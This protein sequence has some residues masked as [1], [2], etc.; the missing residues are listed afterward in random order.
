MLGSELVIRALARRG[1]TTIFSLSG[2]Q[3]MPL[4]DACIDAGIRIVHVR[5]EAAAV[6][7]ADAWS[8]VTGEIGVA[9]LTAAP[10][11]ANGIAPLYSAAQAESPV[12]LLS[13]DSPVSEDGMGAF[14]ELDQV[15]M[16]APLTK[17]SKRVTDARSLVSTVDTAISTAMTD[18]R[19]PVHLA[20]PFDLMTRES[21]IDALPGQMPD[22]L[23]VAPPTAVVESIADLLGHA[24]RPLVLAGPT[25]CRERSRAALQSRS[26]ALG[27][28]IVPMESPRGLR[29]PSLGAIAEVVA[30]AD[31]IILLGKRLDFTTGFG[32]ESVFGKGA[33]VVV[34]D[35]DVDMLRR[36]ERLLG[37][38][39]AARCLSGISVALDALESAVRKPSGDRGEWMARVA[40]ASMERGASIPASPSAIH[41]RALCE[42]VNA[43]LRDVPSPV[44]VCDGGEFGQWAQAFCNA[45][46]RI[47]N[48]MSGAIGGGI[49][50]A[51]AA[52]IARPESTVVLL[53]GDGTAGFHLSEF[54]TAVREQAAIVA[55]IGNDLRW[56]AEHVIQQRTYGEDRLIGCAL[57]ASARYDAAVAGLGGFGASVGRLDELTPTLQAA[58]G[59]HLPACINVQME[60]HPAPV[61][62]RNQVGASAH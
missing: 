57:S 10:G 51:I 6:F 26:Q 59:S 60:G 55:V 52:K 44:L 43:F 23:P 7:M 1:V 33:R 37:D 4:Y 32:R 54:D 5:H 12:L 27:A 35:P 22:V 58:L 9:M 34:I 21:G 53:M 30:E 50:Y 14:Q 19:G 40:A 38:R 3:I 39:L 41:P 47:I 18:R 36:A 28:P 13:G 2:N 8:Q 49:C 16:T 15:A 46:T 31:L 29:D 62:A 42:T 56:N 25:L 17:W 48:G 24:R 11:I 20:L 61:F 45:P